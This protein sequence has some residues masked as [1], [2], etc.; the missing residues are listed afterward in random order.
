RADVPAAGRLPRARGAPDVAERAAV[1]A[2]GE[3]MCQLPVG[4]LVLE[5]GPHART[6]RSRRGRRARARPHRAGRVVQDD[7]PSSPACPAP[8]RG[9]SRGGRCAAWWSAA[10]GATPRQAI[11]P[12]ALEATVCTARAIDRAARS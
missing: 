5:A 6:T 4:F 8:A 12:R 11:A 3:L 7:D 1:G 2:A 9:R 10:S